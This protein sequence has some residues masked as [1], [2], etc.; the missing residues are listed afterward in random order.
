MLPGEAPARPDVQLLFIGVALL[1]GL[2]VG[3][4]SSLPLLVGSGLGSLLAGI[5]IVDGIARTPPSEHK[6][7]TGAVGT[8]S[9]QRPSGLT[10]ELA[11]TGVAAEIGGARP[12]GPR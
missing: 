3:A 11:K 5:V 9:P 12:V 10:F 1:G 6:P 4:F 2:L 8:Y 7:S